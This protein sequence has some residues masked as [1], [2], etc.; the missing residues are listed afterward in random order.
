MYLPAQYGCNSQL[1]IVDENT[2]APPSDPVGRLHWKYLDVTIASCFHPVK[3]WPYFLWLN[4][5]DIA[6]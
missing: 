3:Y 2:N 6:R 5:T 1:Q 4:L